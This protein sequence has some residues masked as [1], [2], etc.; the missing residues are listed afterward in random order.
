M[1][2]HHLNR[3]VHLYLALTLSP[4]FLMYGVS[5]Y[6]FNHP[7]YFDARDKALGQ[8]L[9]KQRPEIPYD[10]PVPEGDLKPLGA[11]IVKEVGLEGAYGAY[12]QGPNQINVYVHTFLHSTQVKYLLDQKKLVVEDRRFRFDHFLTG[13]HAKGGFE[14]H[15]V[16]DTLWGVVVDLVC[17]G[18]LV[19]IATGLFMWC[20]LPSTRHW[21]WAAFLGGAASFGWFV[22]AL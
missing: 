17:L 22:Y 16:Q 11:R 1:T 20:H 21:G 7:Q 4:W 9:W 5:S 3:R 18:F 15:R 19:W 10:V 14:Q 6:V 13:M 12:R 8:P 2:F